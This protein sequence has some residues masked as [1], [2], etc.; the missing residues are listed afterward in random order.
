MPLCILA[1]N[2]DIYIQYKYNYKSIHQLY[3]R[4]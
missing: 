3:A 2:K 1:M 4:I